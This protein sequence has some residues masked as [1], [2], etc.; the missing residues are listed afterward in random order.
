MSIK[1]PNNSVRITQTLLSAYQY[2]FKL[3]NGYE[4]FLKVL[5]REKQPPTQ[6][7]LDGR[8]FEGLINATLDGTPVPEG[9]E[10]KEQVLWCADYLKGSQKQ[11]TIFRDIEI[12]G[13]P[14]TL[15]GVLDFLRA[16]MIFDTKFSKIYS[17]GKYLTSPQTPM[18]FALVPEAKAFEYVI[19]DGKYV[20]REKYTP[21]EVT[22]IEYTIKCFMRFIRQQNLTDTYF[23][24]WQIK[25]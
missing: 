4:D 23:G 11:V 8:R 9:H 22:P 6:A 10:W 7:M 3:D 17:V 14:F 15:Y 2:I 19:C 12:D 24:L 20:Y 21:D 25:N 18:Y 1:K 5:R 16:G 13:I